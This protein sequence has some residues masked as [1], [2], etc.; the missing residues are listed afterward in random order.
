M[1]EY[2]QLKEIIYYPRV[3][4]Q[5][6]FDPTYRCNNNCRHCWLRL[7]PGSEEKQNELSLDEIKRIVDDARKM[8]CSKWAISGGE[9]MIRPDFAEIFE[10]ITR[11]CLNYTLN[12]NGTLI[13]PKIAQI[14]KRKGGNMI[15]I[16]GANAEVH[17]HI[18]RNPGSFEAVMRG[19]AYLKEAG[20]DFIVQIVPLKDNYHQYNDMIS[21]AESLERSWRIG[22][23]W[24]YLSAQGD[25]EINR[26]IRNQRIN[27]RDV[28][29]VDKPN[30]FYEIDDQGETD[31]YNHKARNDCL[32]AVCARERSYFHVDPYGQM[33]FCYFLKNPELRYDLRKGNFKEGWEDFI[34][35]LADKI[36]GGQEYRENCGACQMKKECSWCPVYG[37]L[38]HRRYSAKVEYLCDVAEERKKFKEEWEKNHRRYYQTGGIT[39]RVDSD[40]PIT[41]TTFKSKFKYFRVEGPGEDTVT[42]SHHFSFMPDVNTQKLGKEVYRRAPWRIYRKRDSWI[43]LGFV[44]NAEKE[45]IYQISVYNSDHTRSR[46]YNADSRVF[47]KGNINSLTLYPSDQLLLARLLADREGCY[48]HSSG[49]IFEGKGLLFV[50]HSDAGKS[51]MVKM[52]LDKAEILCDD[53]IIM[54]KVP[55][56]FRIY[57]TWSHGE[58]SDLSPNSTILRAMLFLEKAEEN[59]IIPL[60][61]KNELAQ[62]LLAC[63]IKPLVSV[64]WWEKTFPLVEEMIRKVPCYVLKFDKSGQVVDLLRSI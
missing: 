57:G 2:S 62:R 55:E 21:L 43:Y 4:L 36:R 61:D 51:T 41:E 33:T 22:A 31:R 10:Y 25:P 20:T 1:S 18:T 19:F 34:P 32:F 35:S 53:R 7:S 50:G 12:T 3:P 27:P 8:G 14:L 56:G 45:Y 5:G 13:T 40:L 37:F 60:D 6:K 59:R 39:I 64:D 26:E 30:P 23:P 47:L 16:Y 44:S 11:K 38:E 58:V 28:I 17:D 48:M 63:L 29:E 49:V 24:L 52:L 54:R 46:I 42:I 9:P 15:S